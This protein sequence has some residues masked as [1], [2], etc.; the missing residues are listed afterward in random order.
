LSNTRDILSI[1][2][3][4]SGRAAEALAPTTGPSPAVAVAA[5]DLDGWVGRGL[6]RWCT[7]DLTGARSDLEA[8][9][10]AYVRCNDPLPWALIAR[11]L[12]AETEYRLGA[13]DDAMRHAE[14]GVSI[15]RDSDQDWL[16]AIVHA[17]ASIPL[18]GRGLREPAATH[19]AAAS[20]HLEIAGSEV[21]TALVATAYAHVALADEDYQ[22]VAAALEPLR[23]LKTPAGIMEPDWQPWRAL[24]AEALV[25]LGQCDQ[26]EAVLAPLEARPAN[27]GRSSL[28]VAACRARGILEAA[29]GH[30]EAAEAAFQVALQH[31]AQLPMPFER[32]RLEAAYGRFLCVARR[33]REAAT[34]LVAARDWFAQ[35]DA[36][37]YLERCEQE[38]AVTLGEPSEHGIGPE[39]PLTPQEIVVARLVAAGQTNRQ[40]ATKLVVSVKTI[41]Y[42]LGN[43]YAKLGVT[44]RTQLALVLRGLDRMISAEQQSSS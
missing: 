28:L 44:S 17:V 38:L 15:A 12:L 27:R 18:A 3:A 9:V 40:A 8:A 41:E 33:R 7:D 25:G 11:I 16:R 23:R 29:R 22:G 21:S 24:Y 37:P 2:L 26:A 4:F 43:V 19:A 6:A 42:H 32:G 34:H 36:A 13:W 10:A 20:E 30:P 5:R 31:A 14:D 39:A 1:G 35:L